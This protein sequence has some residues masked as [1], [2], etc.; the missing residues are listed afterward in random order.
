MEL[1]DLGLPVVPNAARVTGLCF[2]LPSRI[3]MVTVADSADSAACRL[4]VRTQQE[5][6]YREIAAPK[7][8]QRLLHRP[9]I[10]ENVPVGF[11]LASDS[12]SDDRT[13]F[14]IDLPAGELIEVPSPAP[15]ASRGVWVSSLLSAAADGSSLHVVAATMPW[16]EADGGYRVTYSIARLS[17]STGTLDMVTDLPTP[18]A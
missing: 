14:R 2:N 13:V 6:R 15:L 12:V 3:L 17:V 8:S 9:V 5:L 16:P 11:V 18:F 1:S 4:F 7:P 10:S